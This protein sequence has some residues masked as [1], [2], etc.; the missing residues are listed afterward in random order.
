MIDKLDIQKGSTILD[1][2][3]GTG[4]LAKV[5]SERVGPE[6]KV[7]AV[8]PD[9][10]RLKI[11]REKYS[12]SNIEYIQADDNT[13]PVSEHYNVVFCNAVIH[14]IKDKKSLLKR[15]YDSLHP[16][17]QF[18]FTTPDGG[19][20]IPTIGK[21]LFDELLGPEFL[22]R[23]LNEAA[24]YLAADVYQSMASSTGFEVTSVT[25][26]N[27]QPQWRNIDHYLNAMHGWFSG[28][29]D[30]AQFDSDTFQ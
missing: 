4:S 15:V 29:F 12:A 17:G 3:C 6:G 28:E 18:A 24:V 8:D 23:M 27:L 9:G 10:E 16:G 13:F 26:K 25:T 1:F 30:P 7:V 14:W 2:G 19:V 11:A 21:K 5:L 20:P 22:H